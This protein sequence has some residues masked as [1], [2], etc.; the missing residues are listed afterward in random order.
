MND[1]IISFTNSYG[2]VGVLILIFLEN[3]FPPIPSELILLASGFLITKTNLNIF[4][5]IIF[6]T[7]GSLLGGILLYY[8]ASLLNKNTLI[9]L[10]NSKALRF[11]NL[12]EKDIDLSFNWFNKTGNISVLICRCIPFLRSL[13]SL[14]AGI[15]KM[16][17]IK[18]LLYTIIGSLV[19][20]SVII[21][22]GYVVGDNFLVINE[23]LKKYS[24]LFVALITIIGVIVIFR[25][26][27]KN[28]KSGIN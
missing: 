14:P 27:R 25:K 10:I 13:I 18:F 26:R 7:L 21:V 12:K 28:E 22:I 4:I 5:M 6:A 1:F 23:V 15:F 9:K 3:I 11:L 8:L 16:S 19:W 2:Y 24:Y 20:N 17:F